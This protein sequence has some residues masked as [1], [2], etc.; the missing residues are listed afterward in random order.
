MEMN[1]DYFKYHYSVSESFGTKFVQLLGPP[2]VPESDFYTLSTNPKRDFP[3]WDEHTA[4][5]NQRFADIAASI[6]QATEE[7]MLKMAHNVFQ[8]TGL[9]KLVLAGGVALNSVANGRIMR[10]SPFKEIYIQPAAG[11]AG[12]AL[13][14]ALH[15]YHVVLG[16]PRCFVQEHN[17]WGAEY[18]EAAMAEALDRWD[19]PYERITEDEAL[20]ERAVESMLRGEVIGWF[21]GRS[22]WGPRALGSR[23][24]LADPRPAEMKDAVNKKIKFREPFRPFAP[25]ILEEHVSDYFSMHDLDE[26]YPPRFML[27]VSPYKKSKLDRVQAVCHY[28]GTGRM[29]TVRREWNPAYYRLIQKFN[30]ATGIPILL[31]TSFNLRGEPI[32]DSPADA[33]DTFHR[34]GLDRM[35]MGPFFVSKNKTR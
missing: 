11:D 17:Y 28:G 9:D 25:A 20:L 12:G 21:R 27:V 4:E 16:K 5:E 34:S 29:Q 14:A 6:Q 23:S 3:G 8:K 31:N 24:I 1:L 15:V 22:E 7:I 13:G 33:M 30:E 10:E 2:R 18:N 35:V 26:Q 19:Y 32:V